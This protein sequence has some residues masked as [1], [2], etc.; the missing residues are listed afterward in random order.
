MTI[1][2]GMGTVELGLVERLKAA[3]VILPSLMNVLW[4]NLQAQLNAGIRDE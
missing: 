1:A 4:S 3:K 2:A